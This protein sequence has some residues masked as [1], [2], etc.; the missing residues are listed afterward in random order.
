MADPLSIVPS[1]VVLLAT[2]VAAAAAD[3]A[4][5]FE[6]ASPLLLELRLPF[7]GY[8]AK[9]RC[10]A[11]PPIF[12]FNLYSYQIKFKYLIGKKKKEREERKS[13]RSLSAWRCHDEG[14]DHF[15]A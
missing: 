12:L 7:A 5:A 6:A 8:G 11:F 13:I 10:V 14:S 3:F 2:A 9:G 4:S 1:V 15:F